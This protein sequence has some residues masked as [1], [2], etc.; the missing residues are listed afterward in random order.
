MAAKNKFGGELLQIAV[1]AGCIAATA[2]GGTPACIAAGSGWATTAVAL[3]NGASNHQALRLG[4]RAAAV[5]YVASHVAGDIGDATTGS[6][7]KVA[8]TK[9]GAHGI[10]GAWSAAAMGG[11]PLAGFT[12]GAISSVVGG[13]IVKQRWDPAAASVITGLAGGLSSVAAGGKFEH[14]FV[15]GAITYLFNHD[16]HESAKERDPLL[17]D[18]DQSR[19]VFKIHRY[20]TDGVVMDGLA[21]SLATDMYFRAIKADEGMIWVERVVKAFRGGFKPNPRGVLSMGASTMTSDA[22]NTSK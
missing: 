3:G 17:L 22:K 12:S 11:N 5:A 18:A 8:A 15:L 21:Q 2:G 6:G 14:G 1:V 10:N 13:H 19:N 16:D 9:A 7:W 20:E 4:L